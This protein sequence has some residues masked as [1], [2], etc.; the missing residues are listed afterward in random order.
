MKQPVNHTPGEKELEHTER[1]THNRSP[2]MSTDPKDVPNGLLIA[3]EGIDGSGKTT[4]ARIAVDALNNR[5]Y[6]AIYLREPTNGPFG[7][8]LRE[9]MVAG[10]EKI[11][12]MEEFELFRSDRE[13]DVR[14]NVLP[15][16]KSGKIVCM[17]RY[18][19]S[20]MAYQGALGLDPAF[21]RAENEKIAPP[22]DLILYFAIPVEEG[23]ARIVA[24]RDAGQNLFEAR[25]YQ[26]KVTAMFDSFAFP[27]LVRCD[28][29]QPLTILHAEVLQHI[30]R[31][32]SKKILS[33]AQ[34]QESS[35]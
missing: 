9:L 30:M 34:R 2:M 14:L 25:E 5:G 11:S 6:S 27:E 26:Q 15:A 19:I 24:S 17:D 22:A 8:H 13:E 4:Q 18:Y 32:V 28:A 29:L 10:R 31:A 12:P 7:T 35:A 20:S 3:F 33:A 1:S 21:I 23:L 16:L